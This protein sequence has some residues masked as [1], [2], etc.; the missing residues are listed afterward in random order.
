MYKNFNEQKSGSTTITPMF[1]LLVTAASVMG[2][3]GGLPVNSYNYEES[4]TFQTENYGMNF[5]QDP[6]IINN[7][8]SYH[9][10]SIEH[11]VD[12]DSVL[13]I[14]NTAITQINSL[15]FINVNNDIDKE[16]DSYFSSLAP[17]KIKKISIRKR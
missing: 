1:M 10:K 13:S 4:T 6:Y 12:T 16:I 5:N 14:V 2:G 9:E 8:L 17:K 15:N 7:S 11:N 3:Q